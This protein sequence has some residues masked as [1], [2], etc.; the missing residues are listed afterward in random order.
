MK[1]TAEAHWLFYDL[2]LSCYRGA[3]RLKA[4][5]YAALRG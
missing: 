5:N 3:M 4:L 1:L 2:G